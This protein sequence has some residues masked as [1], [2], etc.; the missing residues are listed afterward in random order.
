MNALSYISTM[1]VGAVAG[2]AISMTVDR[3]CGTLIEKRNV[4]EMRM[5]TYIAE[6]NEIKNRI[7]KLEEDVG[8]KVVR[9]V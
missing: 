1:A 4:L 2:L 9:D 6:Q 7:Y 3:V 8:M 5:D